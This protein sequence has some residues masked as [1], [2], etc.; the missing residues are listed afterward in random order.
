[1]EP[2]G[3]RPY[4]RAVWE[5]AVAGNSPRR[6]TA[7]AV[8]GDSP[9]PHTVG[10]AQGD[11]TRPGCLACNLPAVEALAVGQDGSRAGCIV[12][13]IGAVGAVHIQ[14][15]VGQSVV[16]PAEAARGTAAVSPEGW[17]S[18]ACLGQVGA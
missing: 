4:S 8:R 14:V 9:H 18:Q 11:H 2:L 5:A 16:D 10:V 13:G 7:A 1:M 3:V 15:V 6:H 17:T 12:V